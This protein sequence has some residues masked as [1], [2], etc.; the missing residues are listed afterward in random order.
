MEF[1]L[2]SVDAM[3]EAYALTL[4]RVYLVFTILPIMS[5]TLLGGALVRNGILLSLSLFSFPLNEGTLPEDLGRLDYLSILLKESLIGLMIGLVVAIPFWIAEGVGFIT[6]NQR[7]STMSNVV[8]PL[9]GDETSPLGIFLSQLL[10][11]FFI[12]SGA[13]LLMMGVIYQ[14]YIYWPVGKMIPTDLTGTDIYLFQQLDFLMRSIVL[15]SAPIV[16]AMFMAEFTL[17]LISRFS[18]QLN[19]FFLAMPIK[20]AVGIFILVI[21]IKF[22]VGHIDKVVD[23]TF[24]DMRYFMENILGLQHE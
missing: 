22:L 1:D 24:D 2:Q 3:I 15:F 8:N 14:S 9:S 21:Y 6:D 23:S 17:A 18:P 4:P 20:S 12:I 10:N 11:T 16:I 19:V 5:K 13:F 7:G